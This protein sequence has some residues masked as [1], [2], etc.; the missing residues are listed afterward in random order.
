MRPTTA[1]RLQVRYYT[2]CGNASAGVVAP[3]GAYESVL[4]GQA[5]LLSGMQSVEELQALDNGDP[6]IAALIASLRGNLTAANRS[7]TYVAG[8]VSCGPVYTIYSGTLNALCS[9]GIVAAIKTWGLATAACVLIY[10]L[11]SAGARLC[12]SHPGDALDPVDE[13]AC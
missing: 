7:L 8:A 3:V 4:Q 6:T 11:V 1:P 2:T 12:W 10:V 13:S 5:T 9:D